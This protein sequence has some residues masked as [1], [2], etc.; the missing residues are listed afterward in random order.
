MSR[1]GH[2]AGSANRWNTVKRLSRRV[3]ARVTILTVC[4]LVC[5]AF[6]AVVTRSG[7]RRHP[8]HHRR[9]KIQHTVT[10]PKSVLATYF[11]QFHEFEE[12]NR[13][14]GR[15]FTDF[16]NVRRT[17]HNVHGQ[18]VVR[19][20]TDAGYYD[21][22]HVDARR[23]QSDLASA[24][25]VTGFVMYHYWFDGAPVMDT[26]LQLML[27]DGF[28]NATFCLSWANEPWTR[29]WD[30]GDG[31]DVLIAQTYDE[32]TWHAH[33]DWLV[34][35]FTH[36]NYWRLDG[37]PVLFVYR[38]DSVPDVE[39]MTTAWQ[40]AAQAHG[41]PGIHFVQTLG[42]AW[43]DGAHVVQPGMTGT[44]EHFPNY[45]EASGW[46]MNQ[47]LSTP[48]ASPHHIYGIGA[49]FDNAPRHAS[50]PTAATVVLSHP[51]T[52]YFWLRQNLARTQPGG[53]VLINAWN[54]WGEG[55]V[56]EPS[57]VWG[58]RWL[59]AVR[60]AVYD[61]ARGR[62]ARLLDDGY[63]ASVPVEPAGIKKSPAS[64]PRICIIV[65]A[66]Q[67]QQTGMFNLHQ[68]LHSLLGLQH[69]AWDAYVINSYGAPSMAAAVK[70]YATAS[71]GRIRLSAI[72]AMTDVTHSGEDAMD[73][74]RAAVGHHCSKHTWALVP[75]GGDWY[76][77][78]AL[79]HLPAH[80]DVVWMRQ[81]AY[82]QS[83][84]SHCAPLTGCAPAGASEA[85][86]GG[87]VFRMQP[88]G[89][90]SAVLAT[91]TTTDTLTK[92]GYRV[93]YHP[94]TACAFYRENSRPSC[95]LVGGFW[96]DHARRPGCYYLSTQPWNASRVD[97]GKFVA[98][99]DACVAER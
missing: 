49:A 77:P 10:R 68:L 7:P 98:S 61:E 30:G 20:A 23:T 89:L 91:F 45:M 82:S 86:L 33:V 31:S 94:P 24:Y 39:R 95:A 6:L 26:P 50:T 54:E 90:R 12:N 66:H 1:R 18:P 64:S 17:S 57:D 97:Y 22:T 19:P 42:K 75:R 78:D 55:A 67:R 62:V 32:R 53:A 11:P 47:V 28:P 46:A 16:T 56:L 79:N 9:L 72:K 43:S 69:T 76:A 15:G 83:E 34:P 29:K 63:V 99:Q 85:H 65:R 37:K 5:A 14:W 59:E 3:A 93:A 81:H 58:V 25:G 27:R 71:G 2:T 13:L 60:D 52:F 70:Q 35:F 4:L 84:T 80:A 92:Q 44:A 51:R 87:R 74:V 96:H 88:D 21:L 48:R 41:L 8:H 36:A 38:A 73:V 40:R